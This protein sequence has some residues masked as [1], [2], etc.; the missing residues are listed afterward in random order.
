[1]LY[2]ML[3][4]TRARVSICGLVAIAMLSTASAQLGTVNSKYAS[5][6]AA[7]VAG[8]T[9][10]APLT[11]IYP[12][13][14]Y[15]TGGVGL[16]NQLQ[17]SIV[18]SGSPETNAIDAVVYW[19]VLGPVTH[20]DSSVTVQRL[21][22]NPGV[23]PAAVTVLGTLIAI[24]GDPCWGSNGNYI[25]RAHLP[26][27]VV[28]G[29]GN[30]L[31]KFAPG[32]SGLSNGADPWVSIA[33]PAMEGAALV[34][35]KKGNHIVSIFDEQAGITFSSSVSYTLSL[36]VPTSGGQVLWDN[37]GSDGQ[38]GDSRFAFGPQEKTFIN[39]V[40]IAGAGGLDNDSDWNGNSALPLPQLFDVTGH[41]ITSAAPAGTLALKVLFHSAGD[42]LTTMANV[43]SQ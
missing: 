38:L 16:R 37:I 24:G 2:K 9:V 8:P 10:P 21:W 34:A 42:C 28:T 33:F 27:T 1:M 19:S 39:G 18:I 14:D 29:N 31:I 6:A 22:P 13:A 4:N 35:V 23:A 32:A 7:N 36:L 41:D 40:K 17:R 12:G 25:F 20:Q 26:T 43:V 11:L 5:K 30:Y 3:L 15:A